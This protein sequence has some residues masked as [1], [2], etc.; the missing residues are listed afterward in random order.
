MAFVMSAKRCSGCQSQYDAGHWAAGRE[1]CPT[2]GERLV[3]VLSQEAFTYEHYDSS[4]DVKF[5]LTGLLNPE[6]RREAW[7]I[8]V[9]GFALTL[10]AFVGRILFVVLGKL[11]G[12]FW[13]VPVWFDILVGL[14]IL[15]GVVAVVWSSRRLV[16]HRRAMRRES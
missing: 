5:D 3:E 15:L 16:Q 8:G 14:M 13:G 4:V 7:V 10:A 12:G 6:Q 9:T 1:H 2:C 11:E